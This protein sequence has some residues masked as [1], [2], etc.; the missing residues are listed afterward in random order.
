MQPTSLPPGK[1]NAHTLSP[2]ASLGD[3]HGTRAGTSSRSHASGGGGLS[4]ASLIGMRQH[5]PSRPSAAQAVVQP[6]HTMQ[7]GRQSPRSAQEEVDT[8][9]NKRVAELGR[10][11][12]QRQKQSQYIK[13][14]QVRVRV[15]RLGRLGHQSHAMAFR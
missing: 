14:L 2:K 8:A 6:T 9:L 15:Y 3:M 11:Y 12:Y 13:Q 5:Q 7:R 10:M 1:E 4:A